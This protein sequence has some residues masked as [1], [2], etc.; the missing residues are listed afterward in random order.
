MC[1]KHLNA[2]KIREYCKSYTILNIPRVYSKDRDTGLIKAL[3]NKVEMDKSKILEYI[4]I[5]EFV[6]YTF[7]ILKQNPKEV[8]YNTK[9]DTILNIENEFLK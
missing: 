5:K 7:M 6:D 9:K 1:L 2:T 4:D 3:K 8:F